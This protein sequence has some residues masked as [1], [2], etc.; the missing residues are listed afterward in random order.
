M[1]V[2]GDRVSVDGPADV[3]TDD[4]VTHLKDH[5]PELLEL[6]RRR[7]A[8]PADVTPHCRHFR[9]DGDGACQHFHPDGACCVPT[10]FMCS[11]WLSRASDGL[12]SR[13][14]NEA[15]AAVEG[16]LKIFP[17]A[18]IVAVERSRGES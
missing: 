1:E 14:P 13:V 12:V 5:K 6:L 7:E 2:K 18:A 15:K 11:E 9:P 16:V 17:G 8:F 4:V 10:R 3:L